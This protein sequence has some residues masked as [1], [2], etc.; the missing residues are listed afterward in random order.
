MKKTCEKNTKDTA[1]ALN[2]IEKDFINDYK[3]KSLRRMA[4]K[5]KLNP[6]NKL[7]MGKFLPKL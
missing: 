3:E 7:N 1:N 6:K 2:L 4:Y 5:L